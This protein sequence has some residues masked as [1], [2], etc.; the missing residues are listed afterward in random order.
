MT[1][2]FNWPPVYTPPPSLLHFGTHF[3]W[4][5]VGHCKYSLRGSEALAPAVCSL[6]S[7]F[8][9][10]FATRRLVWYPTSIVNSLCL[11]CVS[12]F[13]PIRRHNTDRYLLFPGNSHSK[14]QLCHSIKILS[15]LSVKFHPCLSMVDEVAESRFAS[16][17]VALSA[18]AK[19]AL[20]DWIPKDSWL[21][22]VCL[23]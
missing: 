3:A 5:A 18:G 20:F 16:V 8:L 10:P 7:C 9:R 2:R 6:R 1:Q 11:L 13:M 12:V 14:P 4:S 22:A 17:D 23:N 15:N 19:T 21:C